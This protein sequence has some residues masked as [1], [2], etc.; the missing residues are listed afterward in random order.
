MAAIYILC[1]CILKKKIT[2][3]EYY[4]VKFDKIQYQDRCRILFVGG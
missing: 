4:K 2:F 1:K 3:V